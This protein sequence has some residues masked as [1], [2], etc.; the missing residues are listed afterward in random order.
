MD[1]REIK[2][3]IDYIIACVSVFAE[4]YRLSNQQAYAYLC[5]YTAIDFLL[6]YYDVM[7]TQSI[8]SSVE[9]IQLYCYNRG[10]RVR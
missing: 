5:R 8:E 7:H 4:K 6:N 1:K 10:G 9:D 2:N 3:R